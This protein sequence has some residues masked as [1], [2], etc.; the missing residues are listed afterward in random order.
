MGNCNL[1]INRFITTQSAVSVAVFLNPTYIYGRT[2]LTLDTH[3]LCSTADLNTVF[4]NTKYEISRLWLY[5]A[6][7]D[8][9]I[10]VRKL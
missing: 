8:P 5:R 3:S 9:K 2:P 6:Y 4:H 7:A 10:P 1:K